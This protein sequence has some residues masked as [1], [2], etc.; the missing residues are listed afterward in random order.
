M[1]PLWGSFVF[2]FLP[3]CL[4]CILAPLRGWDGLDARP[5]LLF[6]SDLGRVKNLMQPAILDQSGPLYLMN[7]EPEKHLLARRLKPR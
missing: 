2:Y 1:S 6:L 3:C 5:P 7:L 4:R